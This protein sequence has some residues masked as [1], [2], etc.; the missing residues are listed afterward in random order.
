M[1]Q[2]IPVPSL[3]SHKFSYRNFF[4]PLTF[5]SNH[6][7]GKRRMLTENGIRICREEHTTGHPRPL[8]NPVLDL[9]WFNLRLSPNDLWAKPGDLPGESSSN[10]G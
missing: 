6:A 2:T 9:N 10:R 3:N 8:S 5:E 4:L 7:V 1:D